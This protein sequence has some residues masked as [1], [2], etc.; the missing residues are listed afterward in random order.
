MDEQIKT[1]EKPKSP[2]GFKITSIHIIG[3]VILLIII[4]AG[5]VVIKSSAGPVVAV[6]D[7]VS[8]NY[9]GTFT[10]GTVFDSSAGRQPLQFTVG[11]GQVIQGFD[12]AV[13]GMKLNEQK[14]VTL[15]PNQAYGQI[16]PALIVPVPKSSFSN[17]TILV[18]EHVSRTVNATTGQTISGVVTAVNATTVTVDFNSPLAGQT[19]IFKITVVAIKKKG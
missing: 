6:G 11:S 7:T 12:N 4:G 17:Q 2:G 5:Y 1:E 10:N 16:N 15:P 9:T 8:V 13:V 18:G 19:L 3:I 14:T